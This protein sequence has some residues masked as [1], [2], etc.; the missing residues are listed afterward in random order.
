MGNGRM[1]TLI[2]EN[3]RCF[4]SKQLVRLAPL[5]ILVG[6]NSSGKSTL[7]A[8]ARIAWSLGYGGPLVDFN[9]EPFLL[10]AYEQIATYR[11][12]RGGRARA[13]T[14]GCLI[15]PDSDDH[16]HSGPE[17]ITMLG[18]FENIGGQ[19]KLKT[20][21]LDFGSYLISLDFT[22][23][24]GAPGLVVKTPST[25]VRVFGGEQYLP[26]GR[27]AHLGHYLRYLLEQK[28]R[29]PD[30]VRI[31]GV[32]PSRDELEHIERQFQ[33]FNRALG[34]RPYAFAPIRTKPQRTYDPIRDVPKPEGS[35]VPMILARTYSGSPE[36][37]KVLRQALV[38][39]GEASGL[40]TGVEVRRM[41]R[42]E[43]D[44]FHIQVRI[45][46]PAFN[47]VDVGYGVSQ[48]L[49][50]VVD[51]VMHDTQATFLLQQPEVHLH[52]RAQAAL[53]SFLG[54]LAKEQGKRF[55]IETHSDYLLD[56]I[57]MDIRDGK[58]LTHD[59]VSILYFARRN[60]RVQIHNLRLDEHGN[61]VDAPRGYRR[62]FLDEDRKLLEA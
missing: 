52:P 46:G 12:G 37:W 30:R 29:D 40:F 60:G 26:R 17:V 3:V 28:D 7:L 4:H 44:P 53:G 23:H 59:Q 24:Q 18:C 15:S 42:K 39:F 62:F 31:E 25:Q 35:H 36:K 1:N 5:T 55:L 57:R 50:I 33:R 45:A 34:P 19:P 9:E 6:E 2:L 58:H 38:G 56:R 14:V 48:V 41:G 27:I 61:I 49:P 16:D 8:L 10:G 11:G 22:E 13:F 47:L 32:I 51:C 54:I 43:S 21:S 20:W